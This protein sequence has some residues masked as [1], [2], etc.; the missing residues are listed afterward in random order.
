[1]VPSSIHAENTTQIGKRNAENLI[2]GTITGVCVC[3]V[4][5]VCVKIFSS[6]FARSPE[7][8]NMKRILL[9]IPCVPHGGDKISARRR[10]PVCII[11][12]GVR[13]R[14]CPGSTLVGV[15]V[16]QFSLES[17]V[18]MGHNTWSD[19][20]PPATVLVKSTAPYNV[21]IRFEGSR[22]LCNSSSCLAVV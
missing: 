10:R 7:R 15:T 14:R 17:Q 22:T 2:R 4:C 9:L 20:S 8:K 19:H 12:F 18:F 11:P 13:T 6:L 21:N 5:V 3:C 1:M 16:W